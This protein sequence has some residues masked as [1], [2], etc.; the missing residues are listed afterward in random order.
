[1][2]I[3]GI[4]VVYE[5]YKSKN[6]EHIFLNLLKLLTKNYKIIIINNNKYNYQVDHII[7]SNVNQEFSAWDEALATVNTNEYDIII[8][9]NDTF[10][11]RNSWGITKIIKFKRSISKVYN[12]TKYICAGEI[13]Y[14][15]DCFNINGLKSHLWIRTHIFALSYKTYS[16]IGR[17]SFTNE[18]V[19]QLV[20]I[21]SD[22]QL[23]WGNLVS[24]N[25]R[26]RIDKWLYPS[27]NE[28]G[29]YRAKYVKSD[30]KIK[31]AR[32][33]LNEKWLSARLVNIDCEFI[34]FGP[35]PLVKLFMKAYSFFRQKVLHV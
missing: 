5:L 33:I 25:L 29:W 6:V 20:S 15:G 27:P 9:A 11:T 28:F 4:L 16:R 17:I 8:F 31:K 35:K 34:D 30:I 19:N 22:G 13:S 1:M 14:F 23:L 10:C 2:K 32:A 18:E 26:D 24:D 12:S 7:G 21:G 3:L